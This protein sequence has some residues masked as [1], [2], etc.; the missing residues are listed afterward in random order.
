MRCYLLVVFVV[1]STA[2]FSQSKRISHWYFGYGAGLDFSTGNP[3]IDLNGKLT[4]DEACATMSDESG[5]LLFYSNGEKVWNRNHVLMPNGNIIGD[6][7][8]SQGALIVPLP[9]S[10]TLYYL[11]SSVSAKVSVNAG[12]YYSII[13]MN[14]NAGSG[15]ITASKDIPIMLNGSEQLAGTMH[16]NA[17]DY[18]IVGRQLNVDSLKFY[19]WRLTGNGLDAPVISSFYVSNKSVYGSMSFSQDG[20]VMVLSSFGLPYAPVNMYLFDFDTQTGQLTMKNH[21]GLRQGEAGYSNAISPDKKRL[22]VSTF[23]IGQSPSP[24]T[25][26]AQYDLTARDITASR[27]DIDSISSL[28]P[29]DGNF[30]QIRLAPDQKIYVS[31]CRSDFTKS[32]NPNTYFALDSLDVIHTPNLPGLSCQYQKNYLYLNHQPTIFSLPNFISNYTSPVPPA[33]TCIFK[34][35]TFDFRLED[36]CKGWAVRFNYNV[37]AKADSIR[38]DFGDPSSGLDNTSVQP[39]P[40]HTYSRD[41]NYTAALTIF[42]DN[43]ED[44]VLQKNVSVSKRYCDLFIPS[45]FSPN[46]DGLNDVF[47][48]IHGDHIT[49]FNMEV[50]N[51]WGQKIFSSAN[52]KEGWN[53]LYHGIPQPAG[54]YIW[55]IVYDTRQLKNQRLKG[56]LTLTK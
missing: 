37:P 11:F 14:L 43:G 33:N 31:R 4:S 8:S 49:R 36:E 50:F 16:C 53:G 9:G 32:T 39:D 55:N 24:N 19:V 48:L 25:Y 20:S 15:D 2:C 13:D 34:L 44:T 3:T 52:I 46:G 18:W 51:R 29:A 54:L 28:N 5:Q 23:L 45:A 21:I 17:I 47:R 26:L 6:Q 42:H 10:N 7:S 1:V 12:L 35:G 22:Y 38:W 40:L 30:G 56:I 27:I 41:G